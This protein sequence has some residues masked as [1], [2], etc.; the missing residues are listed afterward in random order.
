MT[1]IFVVLV[2]FAL[3]LAA[4]AKLECKNGSGHCDA[5][6]LL[7]DASS[8]LEVKRASDDLQV[9]EGTRRRKQN[10]REC[11]WA[12]CENALNACLFS[13]T[14]CT[15]A[16]ACT[17]QGTFQCQTSLLGITR[18]SDELQAVEGTRR[19]KQNPDKCLWAS[20]ENAL[21]ACLFSDHCC[22][23]TKACAGQGAFHCATT[24]QFLF[25]GTLGSGDSCDQT[26]GNMGKVC[27]MSAM[28]SYMGGNETDDAWTQ[29][30]AA[31]QPSVNCATVKRGRRGDPA[32][33][34][35]ISDCSVPSQGRPLE[36]CS[37]KT[38]NITQR[39][40]WCAF[41]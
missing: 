31:A 13:D 27:N 2:A 28:V 7:V 29:V 37:R 19:R 3:C 26:C 32:W 18:A 35:S 33:Y 21:N 12:S 6:V 25:I 16:K 38:N 1:M 22:A 20:C 4:T 30:F 39:L 14:C 41:P 15:K 9:V 24:V 10:P 36:A 23:K 5:D 11:L 40:C 8:L 17:G 34:P